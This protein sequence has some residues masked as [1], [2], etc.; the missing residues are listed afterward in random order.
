MWLALFGTVASRL[1]DAIKAR[2][3]AK[4]DS[5]RMAADVQIAALQSKLARG[6]NAMV[7]AGLG[8]VALSMCAHAA[9]VAVVSV[10][11]WLGWTVDALPPVYAEMQKAIIV[12]GFGLV[13]VGK[14]FR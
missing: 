6:D 14:F 1:A 8:I 10:F 2:E 3:T 4:T 9:A 13:A 5:E 11:P 12:S 7:Q